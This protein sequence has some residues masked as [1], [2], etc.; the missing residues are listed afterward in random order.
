MVRSEPSPIR[1][2]AVTAAELTA[3]ASTARAPQG[4]GQSR[5]A[6]RQ[7][8]AVKPFAGPCPGGNQRRLGTLEGD[9]GVRIGNLVAT[10]WIGKLRELR[11]FAA[12]SFAHGIGEFRGVVGEEQERRRLAPSSPMNSS[13]ICGESSSRAIAAASASGWASCVS[14]SP[15]ARLP[16]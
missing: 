2:R 1:Q 15:N 14:R 12:P 10:L 4:A 6:Q 7:Q 5:P 8:V 11:K 16:I 3:R 9:G 13:G